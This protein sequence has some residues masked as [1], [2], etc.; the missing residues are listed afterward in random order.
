MNIRKWLL[1]IVSRLLRGAGMG[2]GA[3]GLCLAAWLL[4]FSSSESRAYY[5]F[6]SLI[7]IALGYA[8]YAATLRYIYNEYS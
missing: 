3:T 6:A 7:L 1:I 2:L 4:I 5:G 8:I